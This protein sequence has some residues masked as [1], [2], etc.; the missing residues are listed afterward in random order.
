VAPAHLSSASLPTPSQFSA[1]LDKTVTSAFSPS[2]LLTTARPMPWLK[3]RP[4]G[5]M[6]SGTANPAP[7]CQSDSPSI[8]NAC[9]PGPSNQNANNTASI[10]HV[11]Q[12]WSVIKSSIHPKPPPNGHV[13]KQVE[14]TNVIPDPES[15]SHAVTPQLAGAH[16][17]HK[18]ADDYVS[19]GV[20]PE[21]N[22]K[23]EVSLPPHLPEQG[24]MGFY[25]H[26]ASTRFV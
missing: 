19:N 7:P 23:K 4:N 22:A 6:Q 8:A 12:Q 10:S 16:T 21:E 25:S 1:L 14:S 13:S 11:L 3:L 18:I 5:P 26:L 2:T 9:P 20:H 24:L 15:T 17:K